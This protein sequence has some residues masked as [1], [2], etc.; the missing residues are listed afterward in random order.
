MADPKALVSRSEGQVS[1]ARILIGRELRPHLVLHRSSGFLPF[2]KTLFTGT[3]KCI[4]LPTMQH[5]GGLH[6]KKDYFLERT[7]RGH[8]HAPPPQKKKTISCSCCNSFQLG[9]MPFQSRMG[10]P[11]SQAME[12]RIFFLTSNE[13]PPKTSSVKEPPNARKCMQIHQELPKS[14]A[15]TSAPGGTVPTP[16]AL[17]PAPTSTLVPGEPRRFGGAG[18]GEGLAAA[19]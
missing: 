7:H 3:P 4:I 18:R 11:Q 16:R 14:E 15:K 10:S 8:P 19:G 6:F 9:G 1:E 5:E 2:F 17:R 12:L 13:P